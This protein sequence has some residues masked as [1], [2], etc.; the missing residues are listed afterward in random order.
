MLKNTIVALAAIVGLLVPAKAD[1]S[2]TNLPAN[3]I[4]ISAV[5]DKKDI[6]VIRGD[7]LWLTHIDG[8]FPTN[9]LVNGNSWNPV[10]EGEDS[11]TYTMKNP[12]RFLPMDSRRGL[13]FMS[14]VQTDASVEIIEYPDEFS[15]W[16]LMVSLDNTKGTAPSKIDLTI[17]WKDESVPVILPKNTVPYKPP[18]T[19]P[20]PTPVGLI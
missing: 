15:E 13:F 1:N 20:S 18:K 12:S 5:I 3:T 7:K 6:V 17:S 2:S 8:E 19:A 4:T 11:D 9:V 10:W 16:I 14:T